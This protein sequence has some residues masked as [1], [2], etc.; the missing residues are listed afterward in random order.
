M[1]VNE[2]LPGLATSQSTPRPSSVVFEKRSPGT[3]WENSRA[4]VANPANNLED[5][6]FL[7]GRV[8][9]S[10]HSQWNSQGLD[11]CERWI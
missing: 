2:W 11:V 9:N 5:A 7:G 1:R 10:I 6:I 4:A 3:V 8:H